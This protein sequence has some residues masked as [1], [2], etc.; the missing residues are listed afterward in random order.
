MGPSLS[1]TAG[2]GLVTAADVVPSVL[3]LVDQRV[4]LDPWHHRAQPLTD[5]LDG[6]LGGTAP[7]G[8][9]ARLAGIVLQHP[10]AGKA[11]AL[12][13]GE[14]SLHLGADVLVDDSGTARI[15]AVFGGVRH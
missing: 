2:E 1:R 10:F 13:V 8:L 14:D 11:A 3:A 7:H 5:L 6:V 9:E 15:V 4:L 12:D